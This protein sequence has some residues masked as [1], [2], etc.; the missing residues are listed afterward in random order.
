L[1]AIWCIRSFPQGGWKSF[2]VFVVSLR[3]VG[4]HFLF[5]TNVEDVGYPLLRD[6]YMLIRSTLEFNFIPIP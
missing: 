1:E 4:S 3:V 6:L 5:D 2:G